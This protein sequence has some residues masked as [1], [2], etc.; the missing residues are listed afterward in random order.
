MPKYKRYPLTATEKKRKEA[1]RKRWL[2]H[3]EAIKKKKRIERERARKAKKPKLLASNVLVKEI[4]KINQRIEASGTN[5]SDWREEMYCERPAA[6][7]DDLKNAISDENKL[8][9]KLSKKMNTLLKRVEKTYGKEQR[10]A[11]EEFVDYPTRF[12][13]GVSFGSMTYKE[14]QKIHII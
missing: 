13:R 3:I 6:P 2:K 1:N 8:V 5:I 11:L 14:K 9:D 10:G 7:P 4:Y 12:T